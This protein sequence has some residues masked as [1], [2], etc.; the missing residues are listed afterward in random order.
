MYE[1]NKKQKV[2]PCAKNK[3]DLPCRG[4]LTNIIPKNACKGVCQ[5]SIVRSAIYK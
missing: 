2:M 3:K 5:K 1:I 4:K